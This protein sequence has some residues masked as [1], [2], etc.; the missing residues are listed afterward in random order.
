VHGREL[1]LVTDD[2]ICAVKYGN[3]GATVT[4][5]QVTWEKGP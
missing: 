3:P 5:D 1:I 4:F 2:N